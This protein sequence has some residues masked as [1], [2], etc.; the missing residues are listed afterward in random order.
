MV[1][2]LITADSGKTKASPKPLKGAMKV[3]KKLKGRIGLG[4]NNGDGSASQPVLQFH[5]TRGEH[6]RLSADR[7][8]ARRVDSFCKGI[9]FSQRTVRP[10]EKRS[11]AQIRLPWYVDNDILFHSDSTDFSIGSID[12]EYLSRLV[13]SDLTSR[14]GF[15]GKALPERYVDVGVL[16]AFHFTASGDVMLNVN[17]QDKGVFLTGVDA[18]TPLWI[19]VDIYGNTTAV[20]FVDPRGSLNN[21]PMRNSPTRRSTTSLQSSASSGGVS[22]MAINEHN[23]RPLQQQMP[24]PRSEADLL[25]SMNALNLNRGP[26]QIPSLPLPPIPG[27]QSTSPPAI[28]GS[29]AA[30]AVL[31]NFPPPPPLRHYRH[32]VFQPLTF[33][34]RTH[35]VNIRMG[36]DCRTAVRHDAEFCNGYVLSSRPI[37]PGESW[38][39]QIVQTESIYV[40][41]MGFG[42][43]TCNPASLSST[44]LPDDA[45]QLLDRPEY[46]V[47]S[48]D[49][50][51]G[52]ILGDEI[53]FHL[54]HN[55]EVTMMR[56]RGA[57]TLLMHVDVSLPLW[58][59]FDV[60]GSTRAIRLLGTIC[61]P[62]PAEPPAVIYQ[63]PPRMSPPRP[64]PVQHQPIYQTITS[65]THMQ[66][67]QQQPILSS[68]TA[69]YVETLTHSLSQ[70]AGGA[71]SSSECT[72][73]YERSVDCVL[74]SCGHMCLCYDCALTLYHGGRTAGGQGLCPICRAPIRDVIRAYRS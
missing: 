31:Q 12:F 42:F 62:Q 69:S 5:N 53:E 67:Q 35:G 32:N 73:C 56:N 72:V 44:D 60:Y 47:I 38:V 43:T 65:A 68:G 51:H 25:V 29:S 37:N 11:L 39:V 54:S 22:T 1:T 19:M 64:Q 17:G 16:F 4:S 49:V 15:W 52:P 14:P 2:E 34:P 33:H 23:N 7:S 74:Y 70:S 45:D 46:W 30:P 26:H 24:R 3:I 9:A 63:A 71:G 48:K 59:I 21:N 50:A 57:A 18:R 41:G 6:V 8:T 55:G 36:S 40:G 61:P 10:N 66:Q 13:C 58:A 20:Q 28:H 27:S